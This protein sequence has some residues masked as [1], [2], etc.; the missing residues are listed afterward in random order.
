MYTSTLKPILTPIRQYDLLALDSEGSGRAGDFIIAVLYGSQGADVFYDR[1]KLQKHLFRRENTRKLIIAANLEYDYAVCFQPFGSE[2]EITLVNR[3]WMRAVKRD[4]HGHAWTAYDIQ[5]IAPLSVREMGQII[6]IPKLDTPP[7][8]IKD[9]AYHPSEWTCSAHHRTWCVECY[10]VRDA[11]IAYKFGMMF[12]TGLNE[13]GGE[14]K[15][16][17]ASCAMDLFRRRFLHTEISATLPERNTLAR[18]SYYGGRVEAYKIGTSTNI[19]A[20]DFNSLYPSVMR[21]CEVGDPATYR[22]VDRVRDP[23]KYLDRFGQ[24]FGSLRLPSGFLG[25]LPFRQSGRL[26]FPVGDVSG[27]WTLREVRYALSKGARITDCKSIIYARSTIPLFAGYVDTLYNLRMEYKQA[28][29][30]DQ[31][32]I[33]LMMN[34]LYGKFAQHFETGLQ[35]LIMPPAK[36]RL[37]T[38]A[39]DDP[40]EIAGREAFLRTSS[41]NLQSPHIHVLWASEITSLARIKLHQALEGNDEKIVYCDTDSVHTSGRFETSSALGGLK[42]EYKLDRATY[43]APKEYGGI[44]AEGELI[45]RAKGI[46]PAYRSQY[47]QDGSALFKQ[48]V[49]TMTAI[50]RGGRIAEWVDV[51]KHRRGGAMNRRHEPIPDYN[52]LRVTTYPF[53]T[54]ELD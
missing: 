13:L 4:G 7:A 34:S 46:P 31:I 36:Y 24:F 52:K 44:T 26:Y 3:K 51:E 40:V 1:G 42:L 38:Y 11:E 27:S 23:L 47:L 41:A 6:G 37:E 53:D 32:V 14:L 29:R 28:G 21:D 17:T 25:L 20:Y 45:Q 8:L 49:H 9:A 39:Q 30:A 5:R 18:Q 2:Y 15:M 33:K 12:Q 54:D 50:L 43:I 22:R 10:C 19:N 16:T 35:K 48:P